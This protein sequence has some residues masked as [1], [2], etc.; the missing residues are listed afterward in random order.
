MSRKGGTIGVSRTR[1]DF[2]LYN[3]VHFFFSIKPKNANIFFENRL[4]TSQYSQYEES[5]F[6]SRLLADFW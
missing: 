4:T 3:Q 1:F 5:H 6:A 2:L